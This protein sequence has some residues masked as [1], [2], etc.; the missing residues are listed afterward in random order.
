MYT[1]GVLGA[2]L[3]NSRLEENLI[4]NTKITKVETFPCFPEN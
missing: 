3:I 1:P 2:L 4:A